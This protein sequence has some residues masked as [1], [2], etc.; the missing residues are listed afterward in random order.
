LEKLQ[1][2]E[3][4]SADSQGGCPYMGGADEG[5]RRSMVT[6]RMVT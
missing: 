4:R 3:L 2:A 1:I 6:I 5:V